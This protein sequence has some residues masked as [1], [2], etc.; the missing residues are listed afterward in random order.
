MATEPRLATHVWVG[1]YLAARQAEAVPAYVVARGD[2]DAGSVWITVA[3]LD[4]RARLWAR[5]YDLMTGARVWE[6]AAEDEERA[7]AE[8]VSRERA[9]DRDLWVIEIEARDGDPRLDGMP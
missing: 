3:T 1:A 9:R 2:A 4:G 7:I 5:R 6:L 8:R